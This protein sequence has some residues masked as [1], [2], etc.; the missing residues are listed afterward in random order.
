MSDIDNHCRLFS[1]CH[2]KLCPTHDKNCSR[3]QNDGTLLQSDS[4]SHTSSLS[5]EH[6]LSSTEKPK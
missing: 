3:S 4:T 1:Q 6:C 5:K 2:T